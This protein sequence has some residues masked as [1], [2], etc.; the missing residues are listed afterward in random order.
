MMMFKMKDFVVV[1]LIWNDP[2]VEGVKIHKL[3]IGSLEDKLYK[4]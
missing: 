2:K 4:A 1:T 3:L